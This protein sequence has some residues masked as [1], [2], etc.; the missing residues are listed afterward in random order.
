VVAFGVEIQFDSLGNF[1][2]RGFACVFSGNKYIYGMTTFC[3]KNTRSGA[4]FAGSCSAEAAMCRG[5]SQ[6]LLKRCGCDS[7]LSRGVESRLLAQRLQAHAEKIE[8]FQRVRYGH[9]IN[10][11]VRNVRVYRGWAL[12]K[13]AIEKRAALVQKLAYP[14]AKE[15]SFSEANL[16]VFSTLLRSCSIVNL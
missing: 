8:H 4:T 14:H 2:A 12:N 13:C 15:S 5:H 11:P 6:Q 1:Q 9:V 3:K 7:E 10:V 16:D